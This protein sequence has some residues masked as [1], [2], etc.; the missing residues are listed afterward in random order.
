MD[1]SKSFDVIKARE[2]ILFQKN[3][4]IDSP[5]K[6][7]EKSDFKSR[8]PSPIRRLRTRNVQTEGNISE[9]SSLSSIPGAVGKR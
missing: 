4:S 5:S 1:K 9:S 2:E 7:S 3:A 8:I 6:E